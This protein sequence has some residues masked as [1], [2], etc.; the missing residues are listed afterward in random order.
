MPEFL[1]ELKKDFLMKKEY[2]SILKVTSK[3]ISMCKCPGRMTHSYCATAKVM[4]TRHICCESCQSFF[5]LDLQKEK[6][7]SSQT[8]RTLLKLTLLYIVLQTLI[9]I[10]G[11]VD[12]YMKTQYLVEE[13]TREEDMPSEVGVDASLTI[14]LVVIWLWCVSLNLKNCINRN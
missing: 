13:G 11:R 2:F 10:I 6:M 4:R 7:I 8:I 12:H 1:K 3:F 5:Y 14:S 9:L